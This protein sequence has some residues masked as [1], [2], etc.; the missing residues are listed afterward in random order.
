MSDLVMGFYIYTYI[1]YIN[2]S[3]V[4]LNLVSLLHLFSLFLW[5]NFLP[6][7]Q[8]IGFHGKIESNRTSHQ[9]IRVFNHFATFL[10]NGPFIW[11]GGSTIFI[12]PLSLVS[13]F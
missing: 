11:D 3:C 2:I 1:M 12:L 8:R 7:F 10:P 13:I 6:I 5:K 9:I 4:S